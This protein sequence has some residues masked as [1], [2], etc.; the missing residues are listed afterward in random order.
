MALCARCP[1]VQF[2]KLFVKNNMPDVPDVREH[3]RGKG[4]SEVADELVE[5]GIDTVSAKVK[6]R[7]A[8]MALLAMD[9]TA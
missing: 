2:A 8:V 6:I 9:D 7:N 5:M 1:Q 3:F 4:R